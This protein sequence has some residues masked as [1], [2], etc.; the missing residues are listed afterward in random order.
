MRD[1]VSGDDV[2]Q[3]SSVM[4]RTIAQRRS[5]LARRAAAELLKRGVWVMY[6]HGIDAVEIF[7]V[8]PHRAP[9]PTDRISMLMESDSTRRT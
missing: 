2:I 7:P 3:A 8:K 6:S 4:S 9:S 5:E 1:G